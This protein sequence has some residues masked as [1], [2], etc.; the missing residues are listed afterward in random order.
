MLAKLENIKYASQM[1]WHIIH[2]TC[3]AIGK[4]SQNNKKLQSNSQKIEQILLSPGTKIAPAL[5]SWRQGTSDL[6][7]HQPINRCYS[8]VSLFTILPFFWQFFL[9]FYWSLSLCFP[10]WGLFVFFLLRIYRACSFQFHNVKANCHFN[11]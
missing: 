8:F 1:R 2:E 9:L 4:R 11:C 3:F 6:L 5:H 10:Y 7:S